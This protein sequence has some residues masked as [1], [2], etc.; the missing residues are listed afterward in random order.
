MLYEFKLII[1]RLGF[2]CL[3]LEEEQKGKVLF[4]LEV[5]KMALNQKFRTLT[6]IPGNAGAKVPS[7]GWMWCQGTSQV[8]V[9]TLFADQI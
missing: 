1:R 2:S 5:G 9:P 3:K 7:L 4:L 6:A 8:V